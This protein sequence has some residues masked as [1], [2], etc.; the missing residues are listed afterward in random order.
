MIIPWKNIKKETLQ[1]LIESY[2]GREGTDYGHFEFTLSQKVEQIMR[3]L[4]RGELHITFDTDDESVNIVTVN[5]IKNH[6]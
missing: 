1:R 2:I 6:G 3:Q 4:R 5:D